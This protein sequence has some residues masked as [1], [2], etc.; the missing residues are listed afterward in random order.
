MEIYNPLTGIS[1]DIGVNFTLQN[2]AQIGLTVCG[3][4]DG[5]TTSGHNCST[6]NM[7]DRTFEEIENLVLSRDF[8]SPALA[9]DSED[10]FVVCRKESCD[11][12]KSDDTVVADWITFWPQPE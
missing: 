8:L 2:H 9:W 4:M 12:V 5:N 10:G 7:E 11:L 3:G 6:L 1:C